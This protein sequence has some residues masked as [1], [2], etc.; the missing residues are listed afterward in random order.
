MKKSQT[1]SRDRLVSY[2]N[3]YLEIAEIPDSSPNGLQVQ[4]NARVAKLAFAVDASLQTIQTSAKFKAD[5]IVVHHG[6]F[7]GKHEQIVGNMYKRISALVKANMSLYAAH[8]PLDCHQ[9]VGNNVELARLLDLENLGRFADYHGVTI[10]TLAR[11]EMP[12]HR[13]D[14]IDNIEK[15]LKIKV[16]LLPFGATKVQQIGI[17]SGGAAQFA[18]E[19]KR[20]GCEALITGESSHT[21]YHHAK[22]AKI[23]LIYGGHYATETVGL[24]ALIRHLSSKFSI[25]S[26]FIPAPT[27]Y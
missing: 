25:S 15:T 8:L 2:L 5:M 9:E 16:D 18:E 19:A 13:D 17:I 10:G 6:L 20:S 11:S 21:A 1:V 26:K 22:E 14:L 27:G 23:N 3:E 12:L 4:G 7:W 24:K